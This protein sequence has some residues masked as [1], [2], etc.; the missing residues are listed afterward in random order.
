MVETSS[1]PSGARTGSSEVLSVE[2]AKRGFHC[3]ADADNALF[4]ART[5]KRDP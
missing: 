1:N 4:N 3:L 2:R 5:K